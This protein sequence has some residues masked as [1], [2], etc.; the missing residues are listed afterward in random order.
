MHRHFTKTTK[1]GRDIDH[2][3]ALLK[4]LAVS[5]ILHERIETTRAKAKFAKSFVEKLVTAGKK[6]DSAARRLLMKKIG[7]ERAVSKTIEN[8]APRFKNRPGGYLRIINMGNRYGDNAPMVILEFVEGGKKEETEKK[9][10]STPSKTE[11]KEKK[12]EPKEKS[13]AKKTPVKK[14]KNESESKKTK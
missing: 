2:R 10:E 14:A 8:L 7:D 5:L 3:K 1:L 11:R 13:A 12:D 4:N 6:G 9:I